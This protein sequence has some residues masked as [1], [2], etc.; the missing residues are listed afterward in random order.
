MM[1]V[2]MEKSYVTAGFFRHTMHH[3]ANKIR[4]QLAYQQ[5]AAQVG[6]VGGGLGCALQRAWGAGMQM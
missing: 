4:Q 5:Q 2:E 1:L 6:G 3:R